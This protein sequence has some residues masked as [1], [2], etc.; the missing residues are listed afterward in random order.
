MAHKGQSHFGGGFR[1]RLALVRSRTERQHPGALPPWPG[2]V[3]MLALLLLSSMIGGPAGGCQQPA[4]TTTVPGA[5][6]T[7][8]TDEALR[9]EAQADAR[10]PRSPG[11]QEIAFSFR[12]AESA[13]ATSSAVY[14]AQGK[15]VR[16]LWSA[17]PYGAGNHYELW[18]GKDDYGN[19]APAGRYTIKILYGNVRYDWDGVVGV[20]ESSLA[21]PHNWDATASFPTSLAFAKG[22][23]YVGGGYNEGKIEAYVFDEKDPYTVAPLNMALTTGGMFEYAASDGERVYFV[24]LHYCCEASNAVVAFTLDGQPYSFPQGTVIPPI[25]N[26]PAYFANRQMRPTLALKGVRGVDVAGYK[27]A[28]ITGLAVQRGGNLLATSHGA[29]GGGHLAAS[30]DSISLWNKNTGAPAGTIQGIPSPQKMA[31]DRQGDLW[32]IEGGPVSSWYW[33]SGAK[34]ARIRG[35]GGKNEIREPIMGLENPVDVAVS[36]FNGHLFVADGGGSQQVKEF[37][38]E[39]GKLI[40]TVGK[41]GGYGL[42]GACNATVTPTTFWLD[43]NARSTGFTQPWIAVDEAGDLW[44]GDFTASRILQFHQGKYVRQIAM[45]RWQYQVSVPR[46]RPTRVFAGISGMLEYQVDYSAPLAPGDPTAPGGNGAWRVVR[47]WY[48]CF[49]QAEAG[50]QD[51]KAARLA[52]TETLPNGQTYGSVSFHGGPSGGSNALVK[53]PENG[54]IG[55][56]NNRYPGIRPPWFDPSGN[57]YRY[58]R[59][60][61]PTAEIYTIKRFA[62]TGYDAQGFP[63]WDDGTAIGTLVPDLS[64]GNPVPAC[65]NDGCDFMPSAGGIIPIYAGTSLNTTVAGAPAFHL[66]GLPVN[67]SALQWQAQPEKPIRYP[68]GR[69]SY[70]TLSRENLGYEARAINHDIFAGVS[71]NWQQFSCQFFHYRDDGLLVGQFGWRGS[72]MYSSPGLGYPN[73]WVGQLLAPG[74]CGN[75]V[76]FKIVQVGKDYYIYNTDEGYRAGAHRWHIWNLES[77]HEAA[78]EVALGGT[79]R[80]DPL[81]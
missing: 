45:S 49:L 15:L 51:G 5:N 81:P 26:L 52:S 18:D 47:N 10:G 34:L 16:T 31:F 8:P 13:G 22:K 14:D 70:T 44:V 61:P 3:K 50:Q 12:L 54:K 55:L 75:P 9:E 30:L 36:P 1:R 38:P 53:L 79:V 33:D 24:S 62:I 19:P 6:W 43:F 21:G 23:A 20:T 7:Q 60:G 58:T 2:M 71:G 29:R 78:G 40:A 77:V 67:G 11:A 32:V 69:G 41:P 39:T 76:A 42:G 17:R 80:L 56:V 46:N 48:P 74:F 59:S 35:V 64:K 28:V 27:S 63:L 25:G 37:D 73:P 72:D 68:D 65:W 57:F 66:G 4:R